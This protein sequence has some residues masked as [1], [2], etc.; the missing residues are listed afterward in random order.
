MTMA[1]NGCFRRDEG[2]VEMLAVAAAMLVVRNACGHSL[3]MLQKLRIF[4]FM[5]YIYRAFVI[6]NCFYFFS[7]FVDWYKNN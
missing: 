7:A 4:N 3:K 6:I 2:A 5:L 1:E